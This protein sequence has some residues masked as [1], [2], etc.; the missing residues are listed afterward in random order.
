MAIKRPLP[1]SFFYL[2]QSYYPLGDE[3]RGCHSGVLLFRFW[4]VFPGLRAGAA[5]RITPRAQSP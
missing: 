4:E 5:V 1:L 2:D 3:T